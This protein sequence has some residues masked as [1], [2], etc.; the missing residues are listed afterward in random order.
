VLQ[1]SRFVNV[2]VLSGT[3]LLCASGILWLQQPTLKAL[4]PGLDQTAY[5][6]QEKSEKVALDFLHKVPAFG[7][8]NLIANWAFLQFIQYFGDTPARN[9]TG[10]SLVPKQFEIIVNRDPRFV[11][12]YL[13]ISAACSIFAG[14]PDLTVALMDQG[15]R[16]LDPHNFRDAYYIWLYKAADEVLFLGNTQAAQHSY[17][18]AAQWVTIQGNLQ[19]AAQAQQTAQFLAKNPDSKRVR[20]GAWLLI[21][22]NARDNYTRQRSLQ[23]IQKLGGQVSTQQRDGAIMVEVKMPQ[24]D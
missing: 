19:I 9:Q 6:K 16:S 15:L 24:D 22:N 10:Y 3:A 8:D 4:Q 1:L 14:R 2:I 20:A 7:F 17:K 23:E 13:Y 21:F 5:L 18:T 11:N 12:A